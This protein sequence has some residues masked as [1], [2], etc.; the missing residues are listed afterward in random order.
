MK[1]LSNKIAVI[2]GASKGIG[3]AMAACFAEAGCDLALCARN[4]AAGAGENLSRCHGVRVLTEGCDVRE[5]SSVSQLFEKIRDLFGHIDI[6][7]N[8]AGMVGPSA[9]VESVALKD[10]REA[11]DTNLTGLFLCTRAALPLMRSGGVIVNNLSVAAKRVFR[12]QSA[13]I[14]AKHG[15]KG[16]TDALRVELRERGIRVVGL[17]PGPTNT[18]IWNQFWPQAPR[19]KMMSPETIARAALH[20]VSLPENA[21]IEELVLMPSGGNL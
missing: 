19:E 20:A 5:E 18:D 10:W 21:T 15:G 3:L 9:P 12:G 16:F 7:I 4:V 6:L 13:Y 1:V 2:T 17:Y 8:N 11:I 14:A